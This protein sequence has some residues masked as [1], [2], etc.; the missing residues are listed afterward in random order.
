[1]TETQKESSGLDITNPKYA[2]YSEMM[3]SSLEKELLDL[4]YA[5][6]QKMIIDDPN[7]KE[8]LVKAF[9]L[10]GNLVYVR[11]SQF[12]FVGDK[13]NRSLITLGEDAE[14]I[15]LS[16]RLGAYECTKKLICGVAFECNNS[17]CVVKDSEID[18]PTP[19]T[20]NYA[21]IGNEDIEVLFTNHQDTLYHVLP[22]INL[23]DIKSDPK[24]ILEYTQSIVIVLRKIVWSQLVKDANYFHQKLMKVTT[25]NN[26]L[27]RKVGIYQAKIS[28]VLDL[29]HKEN[30][31]WN[32]A[33]L[34]TD[35][36]KT[37]YATFLKNRKIFNDHLRMLLS[38][39]QKIL[40]TL[41]YIEIVDQ[42]IESVDQM[43]I[44]NFGPV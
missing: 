11:V 17:V 25:H 36:I 7:R 32:Q 35:E 4:N 2:D 15:P 13:N 18:D 10:N 42:T 9:D 3:Q 41:S 39:I 33:R 24:T 43:F 38:G 23:E 44:D 14:L 26:D 8:L 6:I 5:A 19:T 40:T 30:K 34:D 22:I 28:E 37:R 29:L 21:L 16:V 12:G 31:I 1:L 20:T 27:R